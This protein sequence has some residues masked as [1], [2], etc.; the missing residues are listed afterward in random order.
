MS[1]IALRQATRANPPAS[2]KQLGEEALLT[3]L[4]LFGQEGNSD[5]TLA[6]AEA[7]QLLR[8]SKSLEDFRTKVDSLSQKASPGK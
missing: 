4:T 5:G 7:L 6:S 1:Q 8:S 3:H 2:W